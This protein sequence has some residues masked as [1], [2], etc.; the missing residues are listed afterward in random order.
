MASMNTGFLQK[1]AYYPRDCWDDLMALVDSF[2][3]PVWAEVTFRPGRLG[4]RWAR[5]SLLQY[6]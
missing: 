6:Y 3:L 2:D 1:A 5:I 4:E